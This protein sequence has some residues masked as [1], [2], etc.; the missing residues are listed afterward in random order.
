MVNGAKLIGQ[1]PTQDNGSSPRSEGVRSRRKNVQYIMDE[2][3]LTQIR[4]LK[5][6]Q[7]G[8]A[9]GKGAE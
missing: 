6:K 5:G 7:A 1:A 9:R 2:T 3:G 8:S 4:D